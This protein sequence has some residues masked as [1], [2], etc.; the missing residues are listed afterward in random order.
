MAVSAVLSFHGFEY[1]GTFLS[2][3]FI[4]TVGVMGLWF[5]DVITEGRTKSS[6]NIAD[7]SCDPISSGDFT[8]QTKPNSKILNKSVTIQ[9]KDGCKYVDLQ[10]PRNDEE[11]GY[12]L[13]GLIEG[14]G[15]IYL[16][17]LGKTVLNRVL[18]P[19]ISFTSHIN[20]LF[21]YATIQS[22]IGGIGR[23]QKREGNIIRYIIGDI[24]GIKIFIS[25]T[26][27]KY[28]TPISYL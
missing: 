19:K 14:D 25:L 13:A 4:L 15:D 2:L 28:R 9:K 24:E 8:F 18:N 11:L 10:S 6:N 26:H 17:S 20:N 12:Y 16:P 5:K 27:N 21:L 1:G 7:K 3:G 22:R 23:F